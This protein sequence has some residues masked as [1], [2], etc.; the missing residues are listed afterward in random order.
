MDDYGR[1]PR[2]GPCV[3]RRSGK[4]GDM[5]IATVRKVNSSDPLMKNVYLSF[6][7]LISFQTADLDHTL[8]PGCNKAGNKKRDIESDR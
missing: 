5:V 2:T 8:Q 7:G 1:R 6:H 4:N 3:C